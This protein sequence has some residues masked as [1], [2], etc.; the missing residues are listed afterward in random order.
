MPFKYVSAFKENK[1][2]SAINIHYVTKACFRN[3]KTAQKRVKHATQCNPS[4]GCANQVK[5]IELIQGNALLVRRL[6]KY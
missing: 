1:T 2:D 5:K 3:D 6:R 4:I